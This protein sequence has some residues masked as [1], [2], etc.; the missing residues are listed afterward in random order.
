MSRVTV[1]AV[2]IEAMT[3]M[4]SVTANPRTGPEPSQNRTSTAISVALDGSLSGDAEDGGGSNIFYD[5]TCGN[6]SNPSSG[7][8]TP[9]AVCQYR[10]QSVSVTYTATLSDFDTYSKYSKKIKLTTEG[11][12]RIRAHFKATSMNGETYSKW[13][14]ISVY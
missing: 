7:Q 12:W 4:V 3:P 11:S 10:V 5:W 9:L 8:G 13:K 14:Y 6:G 1:T 2:N